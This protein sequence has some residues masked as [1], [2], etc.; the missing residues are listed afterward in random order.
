MHSRLLET[1]SLRQKI[2]GKAGSLMKYSWRF[3][4][5][6]FTCKKKK[7]KGKKMAIFIFSEL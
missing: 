3:L 7:K 6:A 5:S 1:L 2:Y 4:P